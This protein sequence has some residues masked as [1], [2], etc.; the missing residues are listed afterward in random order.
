MQKNSTNQS[1]VTPTKSKRK[2][3]ATWWGIC[4]IIFVFIP[5]GFTAFAVTLAISTT[6]SSYE[7]NN[8]PEKVAEQTKQDADKQAAERQH[9]IDTYAPVYCANQQKIV[10]NEP[11]LLAQGWPN[12]DGKHGVTNEECVTIVTKLYDYL[13]GYAQRSGRIEQIANRK[14]WIG[15]ERIELVYSWGSPRNINRTT[16]AN[17][18]REQWIYGSPLY[19]NGS[20]VYLD[21][22]TVTS[23]QD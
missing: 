19:G 18:T 13:D 5:M 14:I 9:V 10:V 17:G 21:G 16:T 12:A 4:L 2:W 7:Q 23:I 3:Y 20:Y 8:N 6:N 11:N 1:P 22:D 15:M